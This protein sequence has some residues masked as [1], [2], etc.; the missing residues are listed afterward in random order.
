MG[1][2]AEGR[3]R[4]AP[5]GVS[6]TKASHMYRTPY[7]KN[8][9]HH[10]P[11]VEFAHHKRLGFIK[12]SNKEKI[13]TIIPNSTSLTGISGALGGREGRGGRS[14]LTRRRHTIQPIRRLHAISVLPQST[15]K[16]AAP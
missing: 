4:L 10:Q 2:E 13:P 14:G 5:Q 3:K 11:M 8:S 1:Q 12:L 9:K 15:D 6:I 16:V 7:T